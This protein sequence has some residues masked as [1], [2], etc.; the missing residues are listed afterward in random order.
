VSARC[1]QL[2]LPAATP[3]PTINRRV[4]ASPATTDRLSLKGGPAVQKATPQPV[5]D[6][7]TWTVHDVARFLNVPI[8]T[9]YRWRYL[10]YGPVAARVGK[11]LR[12]LPADVHAWLRQQ[13]EPVA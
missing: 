10:G 12:Y 6:N 8:G 13:Q 2:D 1:C 4:R 9:L 11:H 5:I 7:Q 3:T